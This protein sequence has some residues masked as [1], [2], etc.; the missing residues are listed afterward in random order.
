MSCARSAPRH[1][2]NEAEVVG[3]GLTYEQAARKLKKTGTAHAEGDA[4]R[5]MFAQ[6]LAGRVNRAKPERFY[7]YLGHNANLIARYKALCENPG[8]YT[9]AL[10]GL[11][12]TL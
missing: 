2:S 8:A 3:E 1:H 4:L 10:L 7:V 11:P 5:A 9:D 6:L 12:A